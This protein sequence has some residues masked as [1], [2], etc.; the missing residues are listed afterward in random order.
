MRI[1][2]ICFPVKVLGPGNRIGI[3]TTGCNFHCN[4]CMSPELQS[5]D[6]GNEIDVQE[7][8]ATIRKINVP[9]DG[10][11]ISGGEPFEQPEELEQLVK[12]IN[13]EY[14]NDIIIYSG[15][16]IDE[17]IQKRNVLIKN[18]LD[19]IS[20]LIDGRYIEELNDGIGLRGS[21]N[22]SIHIFR[23]QDK[24]ECLKNARRE[25]Q[26]FNYL[27]CEDIVIGLL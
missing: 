26:S 25:L 1:K 23:N 19:N 7:I 16:T 8:M 4:N 12:L 24:Y 9:I 21:S 3:W 5:F 10:F 27:D 13:H 11:T 18:T 6:A 22:Q 15:Y 2:R 17:L 20:V 14:T